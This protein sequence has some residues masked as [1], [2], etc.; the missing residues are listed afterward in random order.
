MGEVTMGDVTIGFN[1]AQI[2]DAREAI[3]G[4]YADLVAKSAEFKEPV[5]SAIE[6]CWFGPDSVKFVTKL[7]EKIEA[8]NIALKEFFEAVAG[9]VGVLVNLKE[10]WVRF[11]NEGI[12]FEDVQ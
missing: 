1:E 7:N 12:Q 8:Q 6:A 5:E 9:D 3:R 2:D 4:D 10:E 11:Q